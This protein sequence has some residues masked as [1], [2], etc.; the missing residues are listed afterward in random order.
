MSC[1]TPAAELSDKAKAVFAEL[2][3]ANSSEAASVLDC[4]N[5][6]AE[7]GGFQATDEFLLGCALEMK[8]YCTHVADALFPMH[9]KPEI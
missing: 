3:S 4:L 6:I 1:Y 7:N 8:E 2:H 5:T 9:D